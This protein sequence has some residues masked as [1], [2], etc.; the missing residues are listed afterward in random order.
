[1][2]KEL[3]STLLGRGI[4][5]NLSQNAINLI[6]QAGFDIV[7]GARPLRRALY[8]L[9]EDKVADMILKDEI[10]SGDSITIDAINDEIVINKG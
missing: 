7:Y 6:S 2:F 9:V 1:M 5:A 8:E 3:E 4:R 10:T